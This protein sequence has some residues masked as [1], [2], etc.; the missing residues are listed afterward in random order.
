MLVSFV[1]TLLAI[2]STSVSATNYATYNL[3]KNDCA[4]GRLVLPPTTLSQREI[5]LSNV[6]NALTVWASYD[7][8]ISNYDS[9]ADPFPIVKNLCE[10][11]DTVTDEGLHLGIT[12]AFAM[13]RGRHTRWTNMA[14][15]DR[16]HTTTEVEFAFIEGSADIA[17][18][19]T[20]VVTSTSTSF[21]LRPLFRQGLLQDQSWK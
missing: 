13:I 16:F 18:K 21:K 15:Y 17:N 2:G 4:A 9:A 19:P 1:V 5:I 14:P 8:K 12:D 11:I 3:L 10:N 6:E 7:S 20:V